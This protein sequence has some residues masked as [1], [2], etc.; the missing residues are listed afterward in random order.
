[1]QPDDPLLTA[2]L[3]AC[4]DIQ[5]LEVQRKDLLPKAVKVPLD[6]ELNEDFTDAVAR[7]TNDKSAFSFPFG[8]ADARKLVAASPSSGLSQSRGKI[9]YSSKTPCDGAHRR[10]SAYHAGMPSPLNSE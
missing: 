9:G 4:A 3:Q 7:L 2:L 6:A 5:E 8:K 10:D 1:M